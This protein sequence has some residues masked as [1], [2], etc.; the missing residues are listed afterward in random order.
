[1]LHLDCVSASLVRPMF[2][3]FQHASNSFTFSS[4]RRL[5]CRSTSNGVYRSA[6][7]ILY[8]E[9]SEH[10]MMQGGRC[11]VNLNRDVC[12]CSQRAVHCPFAFRTHFCIC[13]LFTYV[14]LGFFALYVSFASG[15]INIVRML[16]LILYSQCTGLKFSIWSNV[17]EF[18]FT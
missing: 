18:S 1:M 16:R 2:Q 3:S 5:S 10:E 9:W 8:F 4:F 15:C 17:E 11:V 13:L 6:P 7:G 12:R 14:L